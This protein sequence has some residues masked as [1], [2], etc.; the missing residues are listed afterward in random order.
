MTRSKARK[1]ASET[2]NSA[3]SQM[4]STESNCTNV[5]SRMTPTQSKNLVS[6]GSKNS[7][8][9]SA[10]KRSSS[11][12]DSGVE[13]GQSEPCPKRI[14]GMDSDLEAVTELTS[15]ALHIF[16]LHKRFDEIIEER[17][18]PAKTTQCIMQCGREKGT[19][20]MPCKHNVTCKQCYV[21]WK[22]FCSSKKKHV[23]CP[24][25]KKKVKDNIMIND[26]A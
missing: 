22:L 23:F 4:D 25:C 1:I 6:S 21:L 2:Q 12:L 13:S 16:E 11:C 17:Y 26:I 5:T 15:S 9:V 18:T 7:A 19:L 8:I 24:H 14:H 20:L 3:G 10:K